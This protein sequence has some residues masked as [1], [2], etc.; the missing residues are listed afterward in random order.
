MSYAE[1]SGRGKQRLS[2]ALPTYN[3][4]A[5]NLDDEEEKTFDQ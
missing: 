5:V 4:S 1:S 2:D 3:M